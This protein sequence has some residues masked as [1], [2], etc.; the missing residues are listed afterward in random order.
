MNRV[1]IA[2]EG[3]VTMRAAQSLATHPGVDQ[4]SLLAPAKSAS[5]P[6]VERA[7]GYDLVLGRGVAAEVGA[8]E[9]ITAIVEGT[10]AGQ[11]GLYHASIA[12]LALS[13]AVGT[14]GVDIVGIAEP[15][16]PQGSRRLVFPSPIDARNARE[17][18]LD[19]HELLVASGAGPL[20][21]AI[22]LGGDRH[23]VI[24]DDHH[25][26][27][28]IALAAAA[29]IALN[30]P[31]QGPEPVWTRALDYLRAAVDMGLVIG[32][33]AATGQNTPF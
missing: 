18:R 7:T 17:E 3:E 6:T 19:G 11:A 1:L 33:R 9:G 5:F 12:G 22:V 28:G 31:P 8:D 29:A 30:D 27:A 23:R 24:V 13:L 10:L 32:E 25:F 20:A 16:E 14:Q 15:G 26:M 2:V 4:I 21:A